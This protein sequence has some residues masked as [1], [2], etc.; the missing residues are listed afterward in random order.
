MESTGGEG[1]FSLFGKIQKL[2]EE[3][4]ESKPGIII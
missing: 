1:V 4:I 3:F 2:L